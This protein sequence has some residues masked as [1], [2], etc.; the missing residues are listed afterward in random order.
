[1]VMSGRHSGQIFGAF[2]SVITM[3]LIC[4]IEYNGIVIDMVMAVHRFIP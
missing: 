2:L 1:M 3:F 4:C